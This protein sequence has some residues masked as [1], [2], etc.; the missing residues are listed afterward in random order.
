MKIKKGDINK[1]KDILRESSLMLLTSDS[2]GLFFPLEA[3]EVSG[4]TEEGVVLL[5]VKQEGSRSLVKSG[6]L[7]H[8]DNRGKRR[9]ELAHASTEYAPAFGLRAH[10]DITRE[11]NNLSEKSIELLSTLDCIIVKREQILVTFKI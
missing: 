3:D 11:N 9:V 8:V 7:V 6:L 10:I 2:S 4:T 5:E 1:V